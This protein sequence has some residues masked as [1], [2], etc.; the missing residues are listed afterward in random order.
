MLKNG[1]SCKYIQKP[2]GYEIWLAENEKYAGKILHINKGSRFSLQ[3]H[4][5]KHETLYLYSGL[6]NI[7]INNTTSLMNAGDCQE[8]KPGTVHRVEAINESELFEISTPELDDL[9]RLED[10]YGRINNESNQ[11]KEDR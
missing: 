8:I 3:Y 11:K 7:T 4:K 6:C 1:L 9:V 5:I 2:W 10:D